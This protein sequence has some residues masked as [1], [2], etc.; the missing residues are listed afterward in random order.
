MGE[1]K[2]LGAGSQVMLV[3]ASLVVVIAGMKA[4]A[5]I[6]VPFLLAG[7]IAIISAPPLFFLERRGLP[8]WAALLIV[9]AGIL[10]VGLL[11]MLLVGG[12]ADDF[13]RDLPG[14]QTR[15]KA[16]T[17]DLVDTLARHGIELS[18][19]KLLEYFDP[20]AAMRLATSLL[21][22][23]GGVLTNAFLILLTVIFI[24]FEAASLPTKLRAVLPDPEA[25]F[26][27]FERITGNVQRYMEIKTLMSLAT[28]VCI[29]LWL[30]L[31]GVDY[32]VLWGVFAFLLNYVPNI[33]SIIAAVPAVLLAFAQL[34]AGSAL[35]AGGGYLVVNTVVGNVIEPRYMGRGLGLSTLVVFVS[36]VFWGWVLGPVGMLLSVPLTMTVK[37]ALDSNEETRW[38]AILLGPEKGL[39]E[40]ATDAGEPGEEAGA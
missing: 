14:Y 39:E 30:W 18:K 27:R 29:G 16:A 5:P 23:L 12:S 6:L 7:F 20:G 15:L 2:A 3:L 24:L 36:L 40:T 26:A 31:I 17:G 19:A 34:G 32:P 37:I 13:A 21:S 33:G 4:A 10:V 25:S 9:I 28:G 35:L 8:T 38:L 11:L 1:R 22:G